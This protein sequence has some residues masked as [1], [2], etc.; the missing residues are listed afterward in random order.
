LRDTRGNLLDRREQDFG[1]RQIRIDPNRGLILNGKP[2][3]LHGVGLHQDFMPTGWA[4]SENDVAGVIANLRDMGANTLRLAHYQHGETIHKLADRYGLILWDEIPLVTAWTTRNGQSQA[5]E[6]LIANARQQLRELIA[7][8][9]NHPSVAVWGIANEV[10]FGP[11]RPGFLNNGTTTAPDP[12]PLVRDLNALSHQLDP[13]R[14]TALATCCEDRGMDQIP[15]VAD[16]T[17]VSGPIAISAGI[18]IGP[19][20]WGRIST[21]CMPSAPISRWP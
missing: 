16:I 15:A 18:M 21:N 6:G 13:S 2:T 17:D 1:I 5:S 14:P 12:R 10:D 9:R 8:N 20:D 4:M 19:K 3:P 7:Q 11:N